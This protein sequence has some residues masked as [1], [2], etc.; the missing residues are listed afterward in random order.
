MGSLNRGLLG[1]LSAAMMAL[2]TSSSLTNARMVQGIRTLAS[3][4]LGESG[5]LVASSRN[6][7]RSHGTRAYK[8]AALKKRN[9]RRNCLAHRG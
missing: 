2:S 9:Q 5:D 7:G 4:G 1:M 3:M 6:G 8:R